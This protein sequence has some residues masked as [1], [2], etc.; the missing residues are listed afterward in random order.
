MRDVKTII[1]EPD[2]YKTQ[3]DLRLLPSGQTIPQ[4]AI[5]ITKDGIQL[6]LRP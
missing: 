3:F 6:F 5:I 4:K 1:L 2:E